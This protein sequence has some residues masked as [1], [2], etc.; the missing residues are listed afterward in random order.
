MPLVPIENVGQLGIIQDIPPYNLPPNAWSGGNNVRFLDSGVGKCAGYEETMA[1]C[2]FAPYYIHPYL[3]AGG[4]YYWIAYGATDIAVWNGSVWTDVTRQST[5][6]L[7]GTI[8]NLVTTITL[9]DASDF[10]ASGTIAMGSKAITDG[11]SNGY[12]EV[13]Y[14]GKSTND[15]TGCTRSYN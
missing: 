4:T 8:N 7:N 13:S 10:P 14:S 5:G 12:E 1:T 11:V 3:S 6:A 15:L 2:P 9:S